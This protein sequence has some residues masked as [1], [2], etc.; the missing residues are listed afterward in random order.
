MGAEML[1]RRRKIGVGFFS[2]NG[3]V[4]YEADFHLESIDCVEIGF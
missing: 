4:V 1:D 2:E 3:R